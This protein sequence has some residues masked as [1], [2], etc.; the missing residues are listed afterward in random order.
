ARAATAPTVAVAAPP[1]DGTAPVPTASLRT[2]VRPTSPQ[3]RPQ[4]QVQR[5]RRWPLLV[6][7]LVGA[8]IAGAAVA[9]AVAYVNSDGGTATPP[10][11]TVS[12]PGKTVPPTTLPPATSPNADRDNRDDGHPGR[13]HDVHEQFPQWRPAAP[14]TVPRA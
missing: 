7:W 10:A 1:A 8:M 5:R 4:P 14:A 12:I 3:P 11:A 6:G 13:G 9:G 2:D